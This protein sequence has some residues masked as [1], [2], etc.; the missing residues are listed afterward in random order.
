MKLIL[1]NTSDHQT[2]DHTNK[3]M[4]NDHDTILDKYNRHPEIATFTTQPFFS[5]PDRILL[6]TGT[7]IRHRCWWQVHL[8]PTPQIVCTFDT[9]T[10]LYCPFTPYYSGITAVM[11]EWVPDACQCFVQVTLHPVPSAHGNVTRKNAIFQ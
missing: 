7:Q 8:A 3:I 1:K 4:G 11:V 6:P 9:H 10:L 5:H 2:V